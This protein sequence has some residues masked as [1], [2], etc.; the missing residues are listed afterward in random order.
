MKYLFSE[1]GL[2]LLEFYS[3]TDTLFAF[4]FD[5]TLAKIV[6]TPSDAKM[7]NRTAHLLEAL[8][9]YVPIAIIS[10]RGIQDL[11][12]RLSFQPKYLI[13]NHGLEWASVNPITYDELKPMCSLWKAQL[14]NSLPESLF[15]SGVEIEDKVFSIAIHYRKSRKKSD[16]R[17]LISKALDS[18]EPSP[19][20]ILGKAVYNLVPA[21][22]PHKGMALLELMSQT[23]TPTAFYMGDD[24]TDEDVFSLQD[25]RVLTVRV[26][27]NQKSQAKYFIQ[28]QM[29]VNRVLQ[30]LLHFVKVRSN[31]L[32]I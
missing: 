14:L 12:D 19:R 17:D 30:E 9:Q 16:A 28:E 24:D 6:P 25:A 32:P 11:V 4:D 3:S 20:V 7:S 5:G 2:K 10:G 27:N 31:A 26:G 15:S 21:G 1:S 8:N 13:G 22:A 23:N 18:L 29:E